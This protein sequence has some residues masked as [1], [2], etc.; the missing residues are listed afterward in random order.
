MFEHWEPAE[1]TV[2]ATRRLGNWSRQGLKGPDCP[3]EF[4]VDVRPPG[5][6]TFRTTFHDALMHGYVKHPAQGDVVNVLFDSKSHKVKLSDEYK[7][8]PREADK[9]EA[10]RF[11]ATGDAPPET[12]V[13]NGTG[14]GNPR[15]IGPDDGGVRRISP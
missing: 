5:Q 10:E 3:Y 1:A 13:A 14:E 8:S 15:T 7:F 9:E 11:R 2:V 12:P 4:I 6:E